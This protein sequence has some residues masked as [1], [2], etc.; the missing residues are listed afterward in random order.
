MKLAYCCL[1]VLVLL[2]AACS[3]ETSTDTIATPVAGTGA[4]Q[5]A[6]QQVL[7]PTSPKP[8]SPWCR[9]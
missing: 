5:Q 1:F 4:P 6:A 7:S 9:C 3:A 8:M 2:L